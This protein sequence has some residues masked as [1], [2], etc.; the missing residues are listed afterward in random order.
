V[1]GSAAPGRT[2]S[3]RLLDAIERA[4]NAIPHPTLL[5][6]ALAVLVL[7]LS[8]VAALADLATL[9]PLTGERIEAVNL[10]SGEGL[11]RMLAGA[12][13]NF[14]GFAPLGVVLVAMLG[15]GVAERA[16]LVAALLTRLVR[17]APPRLLTVCVVFAAV[18]S[19]I[20]GDAGIVVLPPL[21][22]I[23]F[24]AA[25]RHPI[26]GLVATYVGVAAGFSANLLVGPSDALLA[27]ISTEAVALVD[28]AY[29]VT[30]AGN[31]WFIAVSAVLVTLVCSWVTDHVTE[32]RLGTFEGDAPSEAAA[33][34]DSDDG[35]G[36]RA[37]GIF[38]LTLGALLALGLVPADGVLRDPA[39]GS[40]VS[41][42]FMDGI[43]V[44]IAV[45]AAGA[46]IAHGFAA[47]TFRSMTEVIEG[48]EETMRSLAVYLVL[49]F[50]AAQFVAWFDWTRLGVILAVEGAAVLQSLGTSNVALL[51][52]LVVLVAVINLFVGSQSAKWAIMGPVFVPMFYLVGVSP[53]ATQMAYRIGDSCTNVI[54]PL[55]PYLALVV[56]IAR[57]YVPTTGIGTLIALM[58]PYSLALLVSWSALLLLW[59]LT[60]L[61]LGPGASMTLAAT[62]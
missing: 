30:A 7:V 23:T 61:P 9:H 48:M 20:G 60:G 53:E 21:A 37:A 15:I 52:S 35:R 42:P 33:T 34:D 8:W 51:L 56:A 24:A 46:G 25:G 2:T 49:I 1:N 5:F 47:G 62:P 6:V 29:E 39:T 26:A 22:A 16:G 3:A 27:G 4:G 17:A 14:T 32:H 38:T 36:P 57:R 50:F 40:I 41:S 43:V 59:A 18:M 54:T 10:L 11:R 13:G 55:I 12:V 31:W 44:V 28:P 19:S 45:W 58:A